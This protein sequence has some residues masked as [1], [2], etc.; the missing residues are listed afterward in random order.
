VSSSLVS[1]L[2]SLPR[3]APVVCFGPRALPSGAASVA[4]AV[5]RS[6]ASSGRPVWSGGARGADRAFVSGARSFSPAAASAVRVF[7]PGP[8]PSPGRFFARSRLALSSASCVA[9]GALVF[10]PPAA[11][12]AVCAG[13]RCAGGSAWSARCALSLGLPLLLVA[14][15]G[16]G[17]WRSR[18]FPGV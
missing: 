10:V 8:G 7:L 12:S 15:S 18:F 13:L 9:G 5:G 1:L 16:P 11:F 2:S 3:G 14:V 17:R 4:R 6:V